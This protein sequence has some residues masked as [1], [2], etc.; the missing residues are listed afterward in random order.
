MQGTTAVCPNTW[1]KSAIKVWEVWTFALKK[2]ELCFTRHQCTVAACVII[3]CD[4]VLLV[5]SLTKGRSH[6]HTPTHTLPH[7][8]T[9]RCPLPLQVSSYHLSQMCTSRPYKKELSEEHAEGFQKLTIC[10]RLTLTACLSRHSPFPAHVMYFHT[11][12]LFF[13]EYILQSLRNDRGMPA[14]ISEITEKSSIIGINNKWRDFDHKKKSIFKME[15]NSC[16]KGTLPVK[17]WY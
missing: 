10:S 12:V 5:N 4:Y 3:V 16:E 6:T 8:H 14:T 13:D 1:K 15:R 7:T 17:I 11:E 2:A 9:H